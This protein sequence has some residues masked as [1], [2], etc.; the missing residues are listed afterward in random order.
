LLDELLPAASENSNA[1]PTPRR[2]SPL[3]DDT[4]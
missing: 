2:P 4:I 3:G 1:S